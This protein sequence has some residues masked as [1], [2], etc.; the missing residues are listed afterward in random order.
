MEDAI[1]YRNF[2]VPSCID[3]LSLVIID[4]EEV[5]GVIPAL[6]EAANSEAAHSERLF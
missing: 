6:V 5:A 3:S 1:S 4:D 2:F